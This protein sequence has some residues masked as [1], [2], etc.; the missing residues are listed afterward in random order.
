MRPFVFAL[1]LAWCVSTQAAPVEVAYQARILAADGGPVSG[2]H[3]VEVALCAAATGTCAYAQSQTL[4]V[5]SGYVSI[6]LGETATLD[7]TALDTLTWVEVRVDGQPLGPRTRLGVVPSSARALSVA[8]GGVGSAAIEDG[9]VSAADLGTNSVGS[10]EIGVD[11]VGSS[12]IAAD[13]VGASEIADG[14]IKAADVDTTAIQRRVTGTCSGGQAIS[15]VAENGTVSCATSVPNMSVS[16]ET[17]H[18]VPNGATNTTNLG[19]A[20]GRRLCFLSRVIV[21]DT[22]ANESQVECHVRISGGNWQLFSNADDGS[23]D[24]DLT[25]AARCLTW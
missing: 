8:D 3:L 24:P 16:G 9:S 2:S 5:E 23:G 4:V 11:A 17:E 6:R 20:D 19:A 10:D 13:A 25:C 1:G 18:Y 7:H 14:T 15:A 12:E 21:H 22:M